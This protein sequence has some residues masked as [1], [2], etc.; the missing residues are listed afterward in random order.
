M[1]KRDKTRIHDDGKAKSWS[2]M[3]SVTV[4]INVRSEL[5]ASTEGVFDKVWTK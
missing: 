2:K 3:R 4:N 5:K 1:E